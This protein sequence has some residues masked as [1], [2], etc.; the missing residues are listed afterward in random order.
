MQSFSIMDLYVLRH[1]EAGQSLP[2]GGRDSQRPLTV[3]GLEEVEQV[4]E[5]VSALGVKIDLVATSPLKRSIQTAQ[6]VAKTLRIK[7]ATI[8]EWDELKPEGKRAELYRKIG[9]FK[10]GS[11]VMLVGHEPYLSTMISEIIFG[12][13]TGEILLK[14]AGLAKIALN[15]LQPRVKGELRWLLTPRQLKKLAK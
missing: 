3:T 14:K 12:N 13:A 5:G 8:E 7:K 10:E 15:S 6:V 4:A 2:A 9:Q 1:G 11:S